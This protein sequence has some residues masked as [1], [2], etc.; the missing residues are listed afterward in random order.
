MVSYLDGSHALS[1]TYSESE[2][3]NYKECPCDLG[4]I[5]NSVA[6]LDLTY[7]EGGNLVGNSMHGCNI[8]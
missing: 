4:S 8:K 3:H 2:E 6:I 5:R 1:N 7:E